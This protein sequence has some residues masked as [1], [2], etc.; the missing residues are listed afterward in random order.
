MSAPGPWFQQTSIKLKLINSKTI[1]FWGGAV[2]VELEGRGG[3]LNRS[4]ISTLG[5]ML[6][7]LSPCTC[8]LWLGDFSG[9]VSKQDCYGCTCHVW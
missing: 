7:F 2:G 5:L 3:T 1:E 6:V 8:H 9:A 4:L